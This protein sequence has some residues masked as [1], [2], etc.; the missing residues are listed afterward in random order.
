MA[1]SNNIQA[2][3]TREKELLWRLRQL[4][5]DQFNEVTSFARLMHD[6]D[7]RV[8]II[9]KARGHNHPEINQLIDALQ[10]LSG[11]TITGS[12]PS[13]AVQ[14]TAAAR[15]SATRRGAMHGVI[16]AFML[17]S[18][19]GAGLGFL[20]SFGILQNWVAAVQ[21]GDGDAAAGENLTISGSILENTLWKTQNTY[22]LEGLVFVEAG[23][24]LTLE[25]GTQILGKP[26]SALIVT[27]DAKIYARGSAAQPIVFTSAQKVGERKRGD[28]GG[29]VMLG[30]APVNRRKNV[31]DDS[32]VGSAH[33]EGIA[34]ED[35]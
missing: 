17:L 28:W 31:N 33:I 11:M 8:E 14:A 32:E 18:A 15:A 9:K 16:F 21:P 22:T 20:A 24:A 3:Q 27:R 5:K 26:G 25:A 13:A 34:E 23:A 10:R 35:C 6:L 1:S 7:Y 12:V 29:L 30:A 2:A 4:L 19:A